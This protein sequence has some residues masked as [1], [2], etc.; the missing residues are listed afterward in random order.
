MEDP[1]LEDILDGMDDLDGFREGPGRMDV[2]EVPEATPQTE[3][4]K[5][6]EPEEPKGPEPEEPKGPEPE[7]PKGPEPEE[8]KAKKRK[9]KSVQFEFKWKEGRLCVT[10]LGRG[11]SIPRNTWVK[12]IRQGSMEEGKDEGDGDVLPWLGQA[13]TKVW[14]DEALLHLDVVAK[15]ATYVFGKGEIS[16]SWPRRR[17]KFVWRPP[18]AEEDAPAVMQEIFSYRSHTARSLHI[19]AYHRFISLQYA[20]ICFN[21]SQYISIYF[22]INIHI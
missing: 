5:G 3:E 11:R 18:K 21:I 19:S 10:A 7:E 13:K 17:S 12:V 8:S 15:Q 22:N 6:P 4:K 20:S 9:T 14:L 2:K 1:D 16:G